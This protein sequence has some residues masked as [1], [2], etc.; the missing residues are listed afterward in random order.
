MSSFL[1]SGPGVLSY[2]YWK[3]DIQNVAQEYLGATPPPISSNGITPLTADLLPIYVDGIIPTKVACFC[4]FRTSSYD[5]NGFIV[6]QTIGGFDS[7]TFFI[8]NATLQQEDNQDLKAHIASYRIVEYPDVRPQ[9]YPLSHRIND[10]ICTS[11]YDWFPFIIIPNLN[12]PG[13][14]FA[15]RIKYKKSDGTTGEAF[16]HFNYTL[17]YNMPYNLATGIR[18]LRLLSWFDLTYPIFVPTTVSWDSITEYTVNVIN[19]TGF[20]WLEVFTTPTF[21]TYGCNCC[22]NKV[23]VRFLNNLGYF[24]CAN[25]SEV[26]ISLLTKSDSW[27]KA[28]KYPLDK[29]D[30]GNRRLNVHSNEKYSVSTCGYEEKHQNWLKELF[31]SPLA[32]IEFDLGSQGQGVVNIPIQILDGEFINRKS[33]GRFEYVTQLTFMMANENIRQRN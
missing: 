32:F 6:P 24:D 1:K 15:L 21:K 19:N 28:L 27:Q 25:F 31:D 20:N 8:L 22:K 9:L 30:G 23:R 16:T 17:V 13:L 4:R 3:F 5:A 7:D 26:D 14:D 2:A 29:S 10:I 33:R 11:D 12:S 18:Q